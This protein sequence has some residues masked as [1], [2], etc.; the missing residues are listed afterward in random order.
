MTVPEEATDMSDCFNARRDLLVA[1]VLAMYGFLWAENTSGSARGWPLA[2]TAIQPPVW[3]MCRE[4]RP[5][6]V[7]RE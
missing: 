2:C 3:L 5:S 1:G 6:T 7:W 4:T